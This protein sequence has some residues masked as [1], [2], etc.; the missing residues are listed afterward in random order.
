MTA[1]I[2]SLDAR[3]VRATV[4]VVSRAAPRTWDARRMR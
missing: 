3:A 1:E 2:V 4:G